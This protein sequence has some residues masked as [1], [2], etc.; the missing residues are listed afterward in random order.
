MGGGWF[1]LW[2]ADLQALLH[3]NHKGLPLER[4]ADSRL[5]ACTGRCWKAVVRS[6]TERVTAWK[7]F[8]YTEVFSGSVFRAA[9]PI[10]W[11]I[12]L[13]DV[14]WTR[15][16]IGASW[17]GERCQDVLVRAPP[18]IEYQGFS[19]TRKASLFGPLY[20]GASWTGVAATVLCVH[21]SLVSFILS[22][23]LMR[24]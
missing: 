1:W 21:P 7:R 24:N 23:C 14:V 4:L 16:C 5:T 19:G 15:S 9:S 17:T 11:V 8:G 22:D 2:Q 20:G 18:L 3:R 12:T 10:I 6:G 13:R